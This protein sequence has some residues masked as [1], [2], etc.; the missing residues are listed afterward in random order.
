M[1]YDY[2][3]WL[4]FWIVGCLLAKSVS[5][6]KSTLNRNKYIYKN[7]SKLPLVL[8]QSFH[9]RVFGLASD[10]TKIR[11]IT[12]FSRQYVCVNRYEFK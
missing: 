10:E 3:I 7:D 5:T 2:H 1:G 12:L 4:T 11:K 9:G 8:F 6:C